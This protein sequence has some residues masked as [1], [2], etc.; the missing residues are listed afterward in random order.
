MAIIELTAD[1]WH[2]CL[3]EAP[4]NG[5]GASTPRSALSGPAAL[6]AT[7]LFLHRLQEQGNISTKRAYVEQDYVVPLT[8]TTHVLHLPH[9]TYLSPQLSP[10]STETSGNLCVLQLVHSSLNT[11]QPL[12]EWLSSWFLLKKK[13]KVKFKPTWISIHSHHSL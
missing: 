9:M 11:T 8:L 2:K 1:L 13:K 4:G 7:H 5:L 3:F 10:H 6:P 12:M